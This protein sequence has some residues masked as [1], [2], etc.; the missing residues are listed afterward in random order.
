MPN[1]PY[2]TVSD[3]IREFRRIPSQNF[4]EVYGEL[5]KNVLLAAQLSNYILIEQKTNV[6]SNKKKYQLLKK[7]DA[8]IYIENQNKEKA[9]DE[10]AAKGKQIFD[11]KEIWK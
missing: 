7:R 5:N 11:V 2:Y 9:G 8:K 3:Y 4:F 10:E 6:S 1:S